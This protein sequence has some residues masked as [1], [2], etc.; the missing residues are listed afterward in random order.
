MESEPEDLDE[1]H[2]EQQQLNS[3][4]QELLLRLQQQHLDP[5]QD[6]LRAV[7]KKVVRWG[8]PSI[9]QGP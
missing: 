4:Q 9:D 1:I 3:Q 6:E 7:V 8:N 2:T 5:W